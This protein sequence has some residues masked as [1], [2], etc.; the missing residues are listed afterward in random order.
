MHV[1]S[2]HTT[3]SIGCTLNF[4]N[5]QPLSPYNYECGAPAAL[6]GSETSVALALYD[7][8]VVVVALLLALLLLHRILHALWPS[9]AAEVPPPAADKTEKD[10]VFGKGRT[11]VAAIAHRR[12]LPLPPSLVFPRLEL[13]LVRISVLGVAEVRE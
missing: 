7:R 4:A 2:I 6:L 8:L 10:T 5:F 13:L 9:G 12:P 3:R 11:A 1:L